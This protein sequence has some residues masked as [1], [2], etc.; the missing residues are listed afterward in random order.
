VLVVFVSVLVLAVAAG[1]SPSAA[2]VGASSGFCRA[3]F[4]ADVDTAKGKAAAALVPAVDAL[5]KAREQ[6]AA[7]PGSVVLADALASTRVRVRDFRAELRAWLA[8]VRVMASEREAAC[9][10]GLGYLPVF[11]R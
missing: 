4:A 3:G 6:L 1:V 7:D 8:G 2:A 10:R 11:S 5:A 9:E